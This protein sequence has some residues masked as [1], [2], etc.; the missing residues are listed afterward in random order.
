MLYDNRIK[1]NT[2]TST[3]MA[4]ANFRPLYWVNASLSYAFTDNS[5]SAIGLGLNLIAGPV[6]IF[7][8]SDYVPTSFADGII[9][10]KTKQLNAQVG[11]SLT[12][13]H[14]SKKKALKNMEF[15]AGTPDI[16]Y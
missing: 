3:L 7:F 13:G 14:N 10:K 12:F 15:P 4:S 11:M 1:N 16:P 9:P 2:S 5:G 8:A 6:N